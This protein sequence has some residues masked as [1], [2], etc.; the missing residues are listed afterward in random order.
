MIIRSSLSRCIHCMD[1]ITVVELLFKPKERRKKY[2][3]I[4]EQLSCSR[5]RLSRPLDAS[6]IEAVRAVAS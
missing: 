3:E 5:C 2:V 1:E 6:P 4:E